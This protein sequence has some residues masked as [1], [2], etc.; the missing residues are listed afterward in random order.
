MY[1]SGIR[2]HMARNNFNQL[3]GGYYGPT[4]IFSTLSLVSYSIKSDIVSR[5]EQDC[6]DFQSLKAEKIIQS[7]KN[8]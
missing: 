7:P 6:T 4:I 2:I 1:C 8:S 3:I 5:E